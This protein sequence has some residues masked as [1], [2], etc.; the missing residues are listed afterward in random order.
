MCLIDIHEEQRKVNRKLGSVLTHRRICSFCFVSSVLFV[1]WSFVL[2]W[3]PKVSSGRGS[4]LPDAT[5]RLHWKVRVSS[6]SNRTT[7][8]ITPPAYETSLYLTV[9]FNAPRQTTSIIPHLLPE[10]YSSIPPPHRNCPTAILVSLVHHLVAG[11]PSQLSFRQHLGAI[12]SPL[13]HAPRNKEAVTWLRSLSRALRT[14]NYIHFEKLTCR[15]AICQLFEDSDSGTNTDKLSTALGSLSISPE[16]NIHSLPRR[17]LEV[18]V[19]KLQERARATAWDVIRAAYREL[20]CTNTPEGDETRDWLARSL[21]L[22]PLVSHAIELDVEIWF[23]Q[24]SELGSVRR[25][26]S[27]VNG[28]WIVCKVR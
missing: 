8:G 7:S 9:F 14:R 6:L 20:S 19:V 13:L 21:C 22:R 12:P 23:E 17:A 18:L 4:L 1:F 27:D 26:D 10:M 2:M 15:S 25:K 5:T 16:D 11:Y 3:S 28:K 24:Q